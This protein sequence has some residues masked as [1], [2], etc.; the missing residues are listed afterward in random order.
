M[1]WKQ[2]NNA[3]CKHPEHLTES[4]RNLVLLFIEWRPRRELPHD[5]N[6]NFLYEEKLVNSRLPTWESVPL[7][8]GYIDPQEGYKYPFEYKIHKVID[9]VGLRHGHY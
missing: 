9:A 1:D 3:K 7:E 8:E 6:W 5:A 4:F 2:T